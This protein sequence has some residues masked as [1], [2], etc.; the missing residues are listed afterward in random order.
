M[1]INYNLLQKYLF[2]FILFTTSCRESTTFRRPDVSNINL[3]VSIERFDEE[4]SGLDSTE[5]LAKN[6]LWQKKYGAFYTDYMVEMLEVGDPRD[7]LYL[8]HLLRQIIQK[9]DYID[10]NNAVRTRYPQ[11]T[12][13]EKDLTK[14]FKYIKYYF[15]EYEMP[16]FISFVSGFA[17]QTPLG[18]NY[19]GIGLDMFLGADSPFY[20]S[21]VKSIPLYLSRRFTP[22]NIAPRVVEVALREDILPDRSARANTLQQMIYNGKILYAMD[23][24]L[25]DTADSLKIGYSKTQME[26]AQRY[27]AD[28]W[29][30][31]MEENLLYNTDYM[32]I[33]KYFTEAPFTPELGENN[34]SAP[35]LGSYMGWM[36]V[37]KYMER[38]PELGLKELFENTNAQEILEESKF[39]GK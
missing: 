16:R 20:P 28:I 33:Q 26:W 27:Q 30:W 12:A 11:L 7:S 4:M 23:I 25:E 35:K 3:Q 5:I 9:K 6:S 18:D 17:Y 38:H 10:L 29:S 22:E 21:L 2:F 15:P 34:E 36:I 1:K 32:R 37:R 19:I 39:K 13:Q 31:F 14:A 8:A 24:A